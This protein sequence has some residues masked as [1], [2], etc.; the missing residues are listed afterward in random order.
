[1]LIFSSTY[2]DQQVVFHKVI[3]VRGD[4]RYDLGLVGGP[5]GVVLRSEGVHVALNVRQHE[6]EDQPGR[7]GRFVQRIQVLF[8]KF[9]LD[10]HGM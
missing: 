7:I 5:C 3:S 2:L 4:G 10:S 9:L 8:K 6:I 1:M